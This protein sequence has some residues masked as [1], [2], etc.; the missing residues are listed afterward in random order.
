MLIR[1]FPN[2]RHRHKGCDAYNI[3]LNAEV[4]RKQ[5]SLPIKMPPIFVLED[6][7]QWYPPGFLIFCALIPDRLLKKWY[8]ALNHL[9][10][11]F[12]AGLVAFLVYEIGDNIQFSIVAI[13]AY[14]LA[15][16]PLQEFSTLNVRPFGTLLFNG[17]LISTW[18]AF[19]D[20]N[21]LAVEPLL[22]AVI[23]A[24]ALFYSH[25]LS[26]QQLWF[27]LPS[28]SIF[29]V[30]WRWGAMFIALYGVSFLLWPRGAWRIMRG[31]WVIISF[32]HR[33]WR[34]LGAHAVR[35]SP[36]YG[37]GV[38]R[39]DFYAGNGVASLKRHILDMVHQNYFVVPFLVGYMS[40]AS[41]LDATGLFLLVW[42][43]TVYSAGFLI[44]TV[45]L[46]RGIGLGRQ[47]YKYAIPPTLVGC[48]LAVQGG[49]II[50]VTFS[51]IAALLGLRQ[52][53]LIIKAQGGPDPQGTEEA[54]DLDG[55][56]QALDKEESG[57]VMTLPVHLAD[58]VC[59]TLRKPVYWGTHSDVFDQ[60]LQNFFPVLQK[61]L[62]HYAADGATTLL[63]DTNYATEGELRLKMR[64]CFS[65]HGRYVI[66]RLEKK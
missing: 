5:K 20:V 23:C 50:S 11:F 19:S 43:V 57:S 66:Y 1:L 60:R 61:Q 32:W 30:D 38:T 48:A 55:A 49:D 8:W 64:N 24:V 12:S 39:T 36:V 17:F 4:L 56:L 27:L 22:V 53:L 40:G 21:F 65:R 9:I 6:E 52:Y 41:T 34:Q 45:P 33:N 29:M 54:E 63:L 59:Y 2:W 18:F 26:L 25:K 47:Y 10:D 37:D 42:C 3:L 7:D 51:A 28:L 16:G 15:A 58:R 44:H 35:Q 31:H 13:L 14:G 46:L 62:S